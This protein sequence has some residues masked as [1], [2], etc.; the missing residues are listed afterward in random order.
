MTDDSGRPIVA[1]LGRAET[2]QEEA[3][4]KAEARLRRR[5]RQ[6]T[7]NLV[8]ALLASLAVV[9]FIVLVVVRP[10]A[11]EMPAVDYRQAARDAQ[12]GFD[13]PLAAPALPE[14][15]RANRAGPKGEGDEH[16]WQIGFLTPGGEYIGL[17]QG[18]DADDRWIADQTADADVT[19]RVDYGGVRW[20]TYDRREVRDPGNLAY[21]LVAGIGRSTIVL[22]GTASDAEFAALATAVAEQLTA[23]S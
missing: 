17:V 12:P 5:A 3:D 16:T 1:E 6:T 9:A 7:F 18:L 21:I 8:L 4:R 22:G 15:W 11:I 14:G 19:D 13:A 20:T 10:Q 23:E 2:P